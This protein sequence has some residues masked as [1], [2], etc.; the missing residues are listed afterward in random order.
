LFGCLRVDGGESD[1]R[2][3]TGTAL[4]PL[5]ETYAIGGKFL[6]AKMNTEEGSMMGEIGA[7]LCQ[8]ATVVRVFLWC[9][10]RFLTEP[11]GFFSGG[12]TKKG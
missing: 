3:W 2:T 7:D 5:R 1:V 10:R 8:T 6:M 11:K 12:W 4:L 9:G